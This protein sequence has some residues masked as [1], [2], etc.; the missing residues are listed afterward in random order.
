MRAEV[1]EPPRTETDR[2]GW[3]QLSALLWC[4]LLP[5]VGPVG[6]SAA[7]CWLVE[8]VC[9]IG[10]SAEA[11]TPDVAKPPRTGTERGSWKCLPPP[12]RCQL[13]AL[14]CSL[15]AAE[16]EALRRSLWR[17][18]LTVAGWLVEVVGAGGWSAEAVKPD[19]AKPP[20]T[21]TER[22]SW[23]RLPTPPRCH[24]LACVCAPKFACL[25]WQCA[26]AGGRCW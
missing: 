25:P 2:G 17:P 24:L 20:R 5:V 7:G 21:G 1:A 3:K 13:L 6:W 10:W 14:R 16:R 4:V 11:V 22:G 15:L 19:A 26:R 12:P 18:E 8:V 9:P 23:K